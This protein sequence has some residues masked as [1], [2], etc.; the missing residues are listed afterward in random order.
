MKADIVLYNGKIFT[1]ASGQ[2]NP[3]SLAVWGNRFVDVGSDEDIKAYI[4]NHTEVINARGN[5]VLPGLN[6]SHCHMASVASEHTL[7]VDCSPERCKTIDDL[8]HVIKKESANIAPGE[9]IVGHGYDETKLKEKRHI[10]RNELDKA[11]DKH[12]VLIKSF[13]Y[14]FGVVNS[15]A[16][17]VAGIDKNTKDPSGGSF[18]RDG[19]GE[20]T[21]LCFEEAFFMWV[22]GFSSGN[23]VIPDYTEEQKA[24]GLRKICMEFN[25]MGITSIG[26]ASSNIDT[27][28]SCQ[29]NEVRDKLTVRINMMIHE[30]HFEKVQ[31]MGARTGFGNDK[32]KIGSIKTFSDGA[33]AGRTAWMSHPYGEDPDYYGIKV[34][35]PEE[36]KR[37]IKMYH[38]AGFQIS[39]HS[40][41]DAAINMVLDAYEKA[42][43][44]NPRKNHRHRIE[45]CT[46]VTDDILARMKK[47]NICAAP[48]ANYIYTQYDKLGVYGDWIDMMFA[49]RTFLDN[50]IPIGASTDFPVVLANPFVSF[51]SLVTRKS[52]EG[53]VLGGGQKISLEEAIRLYTTGSAYLSFDENIKGTIEPGMLADFIVLDRDIFSIPATELSTTGVQYT[54]WNGKIVYQ[55]M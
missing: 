3:T 28:K 38:D 39:V 10:L 17:E 54:I 25:K 36:M 11:T 14:H 51:Q 16:F 4:G 40:N 30:S 43:A 55:N 7:Q 27:V 26:D 41:G 53:D 19:K 29:F 5:S 13:T 45:H 9:W 18:E 42:L 35:E 46:F 49:H 48:F 2:A 37:V 50:N 6:D 44:E 33:C 12:P 32:Y 1:S 24:E 47:M 20:L 52:P 15:K 34:K 31:A 22:P 8:I 23:A 21:G